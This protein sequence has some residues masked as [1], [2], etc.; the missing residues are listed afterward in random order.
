[1]PLV[2][3]A[4][5]TLCLPAIA[6]VPVPPPPQQVS[7]T[8][9]ATACTRAFMARNPDPAARNPDYLAEKLLNAELMSLVPGCRDLKLPFDEAYRARM[10]GPMGFLALGLV[11]RTK[12]I[13][14]AVEASLQ[15]GVRQI[16]ILGAGFDSRAYRLS[17]RDDDVRFFEV[18]LPATQN[19]KKDRVRALF[20]ELPSSVAYVSIDFETQSLADRLAAGG[21]D[22]TQ[23]AVFVWEGVTMYL[24]EAAVNGVLHFVGAQTAPGSAIIF[25]Y[26]LAS[27]IEGSGPE[28]SE[29]RSARLERLAAYGEPW[30]FGIPAGQTRAFVERQGL[31]LVS[32]QN[33]VELFPKYV[34]RDVPETFRDRATGFRM[35]VARVRR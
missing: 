22:R 7:R 6:T 1:M 25:D 23:P 27:V 4:I 32:D 17:K 15:Q 3:C 2:G 5:A 20:G 11:I 26:V 30:V 9:I 10:Q 21:F 14:V 29:T 24:N 34:G 12:H 33:V 13:D 16:V 18:D 19:D 8:A 31:A 28:P 35:A